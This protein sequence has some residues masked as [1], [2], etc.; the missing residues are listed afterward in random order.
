MEE[1]TKDEY[2]ELTKWI[3]CSGNTQI[4]DIMKKLG[5]RDVGSL[6]DGIIRYQK[7][8]VKITE[9]FNKRQK[10]TLDLNLNNLDPVDRERLA[11]Y[12]FCKELL[13]EAGSVVYG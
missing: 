10:L 6:A 9:E 3:A 7:L 11:V 1:L 13:N 12:R 5:Y 2:N 8:N 4:F